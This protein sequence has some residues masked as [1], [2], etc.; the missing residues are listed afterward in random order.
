MLAP[1]PRP[2]SHWFYSST[3]GTIALEFACYL[4]IF[5]VVFLYIWRAFS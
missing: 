4:L 3:L 2:K 1:T 5:V